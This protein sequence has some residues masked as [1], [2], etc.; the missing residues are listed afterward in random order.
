MRP[1]GERSL[2]EPLP[3]ALAAS[4]GMPATFTSNAGISAETSIWPPRPCACPVWPAW[5][6]RGADTR[7]PPAGGPALHQEKVVNAGPVVLGLPIAVEIGHMMLA[8]GEG[9]H[10]DQHAELLEM[11]PMQVAVQ[12]AK[13]LVERVGHAY[14]ATHEA[15]LPELM[16]NGR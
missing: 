6:R 3:A 13:E 1:L 10:H 11:V 5:N 16:V 14:N 4:F 7:C 15:M 12:G 9:H 8:P 2:S